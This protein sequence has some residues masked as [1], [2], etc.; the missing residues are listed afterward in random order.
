MRRQWRAAALSAGDGASGCARPR[1]AHSAFFVAGPGT[2]D[3]IA[4]AKVVA[5]F[6]RRVL[7]LAEMLVDRPTVGA[8]WMLGVN[9][10]R[11]TAALDIAN[12]L[13]GLAYTLFHGHRA[14]LGQLAVI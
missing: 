2:D 13:A 6:K 7:G 12:D 9:R 5:A 4:A 11:G 1:Q 14:G 3:T 10:K 8:A